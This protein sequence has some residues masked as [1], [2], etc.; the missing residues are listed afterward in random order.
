MSPIDAQ[1]SGISLLR[2]GPGFRVPYGHTHNLQEEI[3]V[4]IEGS[5]R[6]NV[7]GEIVEMTPFTA[8]RIAPAGMRAYEGGP[9][10][11]TFL[12]I[13]APNTGPG[14]GKTEDGWWAE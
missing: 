1:N 14:D 8:V 12:A 3:Y 5:M 11:A 6:L 13:G 2:L 9:E 10:G 7:D 4:C